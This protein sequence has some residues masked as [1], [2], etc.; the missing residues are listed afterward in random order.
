MIKIQNYQKRNKLNILNKQK[1]PKNS[2]QESGSWNEATIFHLKNP[3]MDYKSQKIPKQAPL[4]LSFTSID[5]KH[6][7]SWLNHKTAQHHLTFLK[8]CNFWL[9]SIPKE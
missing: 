9:L 1:R 2:F 7:E 3:S 8:G 5:P 6:K 4:D